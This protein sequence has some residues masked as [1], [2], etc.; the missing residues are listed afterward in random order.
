MVGLGPGSG[1]EAECADVG[2]AQ[3]RGDVQ[4]VTQLPG[5]PEPTAVVSVV[6]GRQVAGER[7]GG[8][9]AAVV[10]VEG[11]CRAIAVDVEPTGWA[12]GVLRAGVGLSFDD[13]VRIPHGFRVAGNAA[14]READ[15][16][17][18]KPV[19]STATHVHLQVCLPAPGLESGTLPW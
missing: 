10:D 12:V 1:K 19:C 6:G 5:D 3:V 14:R 16:D 9:E 7:V 2:A 15:T 4:G 8:A 18:A 17:G 13:E 11:E